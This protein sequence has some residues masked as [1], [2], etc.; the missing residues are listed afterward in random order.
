M[1]KKLRGGLLVG[2][3]YMLS[4]LSWWNDIFFNLPIALLFGYLVS[5][6][7][8]NWFLPFT[9]IGYWL[10]NVLGI[11]MMQMGTMDM[12][13][14]EEERNLKRDLLLGLGGSTVY[15]I[16]VALLVYF[17]ILEIPAFPL[18]P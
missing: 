8:P 17:H 14:T 11:V 15:T 16:V 18:N 1:F 6:A 5:W 4:P 3:G 13:L 2:I 10:S 12:F 7:K 9:I